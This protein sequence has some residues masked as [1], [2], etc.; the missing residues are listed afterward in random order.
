MGGPS[1]AVGMPCGE[2]SGKRGKRASVENRIRRGVPISEPTEKFRKAQL[3]VGNEAV[4]I[5]AYIKLL[6]W[7]HPTAL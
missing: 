2:V 5:A 4:R 3:L 1:A 7:T 6:V